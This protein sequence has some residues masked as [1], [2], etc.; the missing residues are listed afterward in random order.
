MFISSAQIDFD[1]ARIGADRIERA[2]RQTFE[3]IK[4]IDAVIVGIY[5]K[6]ADQPLEDAQYTRRYGGGN[7]RA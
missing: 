5:D 2:F 4:P 6:F 7:G 3:G 1:H